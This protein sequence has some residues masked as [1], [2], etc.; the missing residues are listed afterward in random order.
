[1]KFI[2]GDSG[3]FEIGFWEMVLVAVVT[4]IVVGPE[5]LPSLA[6]NVGLWLSR[7]RRV[8][9]DIKAEVDLELQIA[10][11]KKSLLQSGA[12]VDYLKDLSK[13]IVPSDIEVKD[14]VE[15]NSI[16]TADC[17]KCMPADPELH[18]INSNPFKKPLSV[19]LAIAAGQPMGKQQLNTKPTT[20]TLPQLPNYP[21][22]T[23][24]D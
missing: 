23:S 8:V 24:A 12:N 17:G 15:L 9:T 20:I 21:T 22:P 14:T 3:M 13:G 16:Q 7:A 18:D 4:L 11:I 2:N 10:E 6:R 19:H 5:R 1:M